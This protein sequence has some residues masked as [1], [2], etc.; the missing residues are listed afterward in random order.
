MATASGDATPPH[1]EGPPSSGAAAR[2]RRSAPGDELHRR[3]PGGL[4]AGGH[5]DHLLDRFRAVVE[6]NVSGT[7]ELLARVEAVARRAVAERPASAPGAADVL[8]RLVD[9][10]LSSVAEVSRHTLALLDGLVSVAERALL[11]AAAEGGPPAAEAAAGRAVGVGLD[12]DQAS[13][14]ERS[15]AAR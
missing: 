1:G 3:E 8:A 11:P 10:G 15:A 12:G 4:P 9:A 14:A 13:E 5:V 6:A 7:V 2:G